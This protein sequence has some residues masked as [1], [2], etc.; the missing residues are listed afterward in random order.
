MLLMHGLIAFAQSFSA[1]HWLKASAL[2]AVESTKKLFYDERCKNVN[3]ETGIG[4]YFQ[5]RLVE[6][7][8]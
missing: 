6:M 1:Y 3:C 4:P 2:S 5:R 8:F 7:A